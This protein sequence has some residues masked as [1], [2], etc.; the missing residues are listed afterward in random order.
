MSKLPFP[1]GK[2]LRDTTP[3]PAALDRMWSGVRGRI[4][5]V[6][7]KR[8]IWIAAPLFAAVA[9][10]VLIWSHRPR[11]TTGPLALAS[12]GAIGALENSSR[13][14]RIVSFNDGSRV[15]LGSGSLVEPLVNDEQHFAL[16]LRR[17][18]ATFELPRDHARKWT[19]ESGAT[20]EVMATKFSVSR[21]EAE[22]EVRVFDGVLV[23]RGE[24]V[25]GR[26]QNLAANQQLTLSLSAPSANRLTPAAPAEQPAT[27]TIKAPSPGR[28]RSAAIP[29]TP[30]PSR[31]SLTSEHQDGEAD[32]A[33]GSD[34]VADAA[35]KPSS[36][37]K[38]LRL[39]D[40]ARRSGHP[41]EALALLGRLVEGFPNDRRAALAAFTRGRIAADDLDQPR[42]AAESFA[43]AIA[44]GLPDAL[45]EDAFLRLVE[46]RLALGDRAAATAAVRQYEERFPRGRFAQRM[47]QLTEVR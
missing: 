30:S 8:R 35:A 22:V 43:R 13:T 33:L 46:S 23:V 38:L 12:G 24:R 32:R 19:L 3:D 31:R 5:P 47:K 27:G 29:A 25:P 17:G 1:L 14:A 37:E 18:G 36:V 45:T 39:A 40:G 41:A 20:I 9:A 10:C 11:P 44:L 6:P 42:Q 4:A 28:T 16:A 2:A 21:S 26:I 15:V 7:F 34:E